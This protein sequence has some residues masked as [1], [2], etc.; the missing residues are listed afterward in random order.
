MRFFS[1]RSW[2]WLVAAVLCFGL[3]GFARGADGPS[4]D[5]L[6]KKIDVG[7]FR[8]AAGKE[9]RLKDLPDQKA[10][11]VVFLSFECPVCAGYSQPLADL[12][13][14]YAGRGVA[15]VGLCTSQDDDAAQVARHAEEFKLPFPVFKDDQLAAAGAFKATI[16]PEVF[17]LDANRVLRYRGRIDDGYAARLKRNSK[18]T[19]QDLRAALDAVLAGK[20]VSE[21]AT[22]AIGCPIQRDLA[23]VA[24]GGKV[25]FHR[26]VLPILQNNCQTCHRPGE[27]GPFSLLTYRQAVNWASDIKAY[28][29]ERKMPP[30]KPVDGPAFH[31]E[32][33][34]SAQDIA[35]LAA[36]VDGGT[37]EGDPKDAPAPRHFVEGWQHGK[38]D[39]VLTVDG[40]FQ[41]GA[42]GPDVFRCFVL[43]TNLPEDKYITAV[44]LRP[45]NP[46]IVHHALLFLDTT[47][48]A[49]KLEQQEKERANKSTEKDAG[50]G[51]SAS[52]GVGFLPR[53]GLGGW[54]PGQ[55]PRELPDGSGY[56]LP[57]GADVVAQVHYHRNGRAEKDRTRLGLYFATKPVSKRFQSMVIPGKFWAI[58]AGDDHY[59]VTGSIVVRQDCDLHSVMPHMHLLGRE[60]KVTMTPPDG[61]SRTLVAIN[62]WEYNW[63]ETYFFQDAIP[64]K[65]G[66][67]FDI[68]AIYDNTAKNPNNPNSPPKPVFFGQFTTNEMCFGFLGA[69]SDKPGRI[70]FDRNVGQ[71]AAADGKE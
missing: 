48:Q 37:P 35:T 18:V 65:A 52:M 39:L 67:R 25:T 16:T 2:K 23:P 29:Q 24:A 45:G 54:A 19:R 38:P 49:R 7:A 58:P 5:K 50:P 57:R 30:W 28:T 44:E 59:R 61:T 11:V 66:T 1:T 46:R 40:D 34:L 27:V 9:F 55:M 47:G 69:T 42:S 64:V 71:R 22:Q 53:G 26:D 8:D 70:R 10:V 41:V 4:T 51:Y 36:W 63:Q 3:H 33:K 13:K 62:D 17:V 15:F 12:A 32:R 14:E 6:G 56:F 21:P 68:E 20:P 31:G 60:I 43:P